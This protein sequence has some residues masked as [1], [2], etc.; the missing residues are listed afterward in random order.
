[1]KFTSIGPKQVNTLKSVGGGRLED[2]TWYVWTEA[3]VD[4]EQ[5]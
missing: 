4:V 1:M 2:V 5:R 3:G